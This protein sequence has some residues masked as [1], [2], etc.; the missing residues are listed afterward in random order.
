MV[1]RTNVAR[2]VDGEASLMGVSVSPAVST[3]GGSAGWERKFDLALVR[4][5]E[6]PELRADTCWRSMVTTTE[7]GCLVLQESQ[8]GLRYLAERTGVA[9]SLRIACLIYGKSSSSSWGRKHSGRP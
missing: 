4:E 1:N 6:D 7:V 3:L 2:R 8:S 9:L 5:D